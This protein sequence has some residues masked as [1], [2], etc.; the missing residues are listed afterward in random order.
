VPGTTLS[1]RDCLAALSA[2]AAGLAWSALPGCAP[3][4][5]RPN[6]VLV[7]A[8]DLGTTDLG[9]YGAAD[10]R[11]PTLDTL[12]AEGVR[13]T[14][15]YA[16]APVC[17]PSR[18]SLLSGRYPA[19]CVGDDGLRPD[20]TTIAEMLR[21]AGYRTGCFGKWHLGHPVDH[22]PQAQG[23]DEFLGFLHGA[24]DN[25][26][27]TFYWGGD[28]RP[29]LRR[30][31]EPY[32]EDGAYFPDIVTREATRF[33]RA[34]REQPFFLYLPLNL[35]HYPLQPDTDLLP[36]YAHLPDGRRQYA[37]CVTTMDRRIGRVLSTLDE[38]GL[39]DDTIVLFLSDHGHSEEERALHGGGR[40]APFR[41]HK[42]QLTEGGIR[43]PLLMR[44]PGRVPP[45][46]VR[47]QA[48]G[49]LDLLPTIA[50]WTGAT[51]P[52]HLDGV[53][54]VDVVA[55]DDA[56][57]PHRHLFWS[58]H[59][60]W[61]VRHERWKTVGNL[62]TRAISLYDLAADPG[63]TRDVAGQHPEIVSYCTA[64]LQTWARSLGSVTASAAVD[65]VL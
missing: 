38:A 23:F 53:S 42:G 50:A 13:F 35:P 59:D 24:A 64:A 44:A 5:R 37:A 10:L 9:C 25:W 62:S 56:A 6:I 43:V 7:L 47:Q 46:S 8:D 65:A 40:A 41:G 32:R 16:M 14:D 55:D 48:V 17:M 22:Q 28:Y 1:R 18:A 21:D 15:A 29:V 39:R 60:D 4:Q 63:E 11:T 36:T 20:E 54:L 51:L 19:R 52:S 57:S 3:G 33:I 30:G 45:G 12:A 34:H 31:G 61:A 49:A 26:S 27:H 58:Y 2:A